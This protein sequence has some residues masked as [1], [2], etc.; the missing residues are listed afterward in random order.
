MTYIVMAEI[1]DKRRFM[2]F[3]TGQTDLYSTDISLD[4]NPSTRWTTC[5]AFFE[6]NLSETDAAFELRAKREIL[7]KYDQ[8]HEIQTIAK[9]VRL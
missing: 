5:T 8:E 1:D 9:G 2:T 3:A 6:R 4:T 7:K